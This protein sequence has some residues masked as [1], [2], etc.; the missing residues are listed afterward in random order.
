MAEVATIIRNNRGDTLLYFLV[1][2]IRRY[3]AARRERYPR[4]YP[5][6]HVTSQAYG[7][8]YGPWKMAVRT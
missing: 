8:A 6:G 4:V 3:T 2:A 5:T 7:C 1:V